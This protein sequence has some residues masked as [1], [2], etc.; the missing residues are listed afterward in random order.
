MVYCLC[1]PTRLCLPLS[2]VSVGLFKVATHARR[3]CSVVSHQLSS[4]CYYF[5][6]SIVS[7]L[8]GGSPWFEGPRSNCCRVLNELGQL[9]SICWRGRT[10]RALPSPPPQLKRLLE[11]DGKVQSGSAAGLR[12]A[13]QD[14]PAASAFPSMVTAHSNWIKWPLLYYSGDPHSSATFFFLMF[15]EKIS[16]SSF[17]LPCLLSGF[18]THKTGA[19]HTG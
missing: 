16:L 14:W 11:G 18:C 4:Y 8:K 5:F 2:S 9:S 1:W 7:D 12:T 13:S 17:E 15:K 6:I 10:S 19:S 3:E